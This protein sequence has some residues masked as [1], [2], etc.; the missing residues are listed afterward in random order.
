MSAA[1]A[2]TRLRNQSISVPR[3]RDAAD[4]VSWLGAVQAQEYEPAKWGLGLRIPGSV[5]PEIERAFE[6]G[7]ILRTHVM[8]PTWHF[9]T[10]ADIRWILMLTA[11][12]VHALNAYMYRQSEL[13][14]PLLRQ[15]TDI[16]IEALRGGNQLTRAELAVILTQTGIIASGFRLSYIMMY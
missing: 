13:D 5:E 15:S 14:E 11:P 4:V 16:I 12:R 2:Q 9:V 6:E 8:R 3:L 10:P 1:I 7:R